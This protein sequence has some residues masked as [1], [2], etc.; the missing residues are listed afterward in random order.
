MAGRPRLFKDEVLIDRAMEVFWMKGFHAAS[1]QDLMQAMDIGQGS[2]YR[3][4]PRG[5]RELYQK[6]LSRFLQK[7]IDTFYEGLDKSQDPVQYVKDYFYAIVDR[8]ERARMN[9]CFLGNA[10][11]E[12]CNLDEETK[13]LSVSLLSKL[14]DGFEKAI[15]NGQKIGLIDKQRSSGM[16]ATYL[17]N[18]W[19][20]INVTHRMHM[21]DKQLKELIE[22]NLKV[23][24]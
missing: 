11:V 3:S 16:I 6:S 12:L 13:S 19:N 4:F 23:L 14:K 15:V 10:I 17:I 2:F 5:K 1:A 9:G 7:S 21:D 8:S 20:G 18:F 24:E 22:M